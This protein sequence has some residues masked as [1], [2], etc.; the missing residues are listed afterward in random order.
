MTLAMI[1]LVAILSGCAKPRS[2]SS[3]PFA[4]PTSSQAPGGPSEPQLNG[5]LQAAA[6]MPPSTPPPVVIP[7]APSP[8]PISRAQTPT[9]TAIQVSKPT[10]TPKPTPI[11]DLP[12]NDL[13]DSYYKAALWAKVPNSRAWTEAV[14]KSVRKVQPSLEIAS[15]IDDFCP[16]YEKAKQ[17]LKEICWLRLVS[18]VAELESKFKPSST[19][20]EPEGEI[21]IG[22]MQISQGECVL[23]G[24]KSPNILDPVNNLK[25]AIGIMAN[26]IKTDHYIDGPIWAR[27]AAAY[28]STLRPPYEFLGLYLGKK[29][30]VIDFTKTYSAY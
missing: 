14:I 13:P 20:K 26:L 18:G 21:S 11:I 1:G 15:D 30:E 28:W 24:N 19:F 5:K 23:H 8:T 17:R 2:D 9:P 10:P 6:P 22:L 25:C 12:K 27:G 3:S 7:V 16:K 4:P 29:S